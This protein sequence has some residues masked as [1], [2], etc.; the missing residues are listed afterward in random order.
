MF[1]R[2]LYDMDKKENKKATRKLYYTLRQI[3]HH[4][5]R[6]QVPVISVGKNR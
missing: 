1:C 3:V 4:I 2:I 5:P 6:W